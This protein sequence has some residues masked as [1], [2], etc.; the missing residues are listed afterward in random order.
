MNERS[1]RVLEFDKVKN[2]LIDFA[3][4]E[5]GKEKC[6][7]IKPIN[8]IDEI[9]FLQEQTSEANR[10][11]SKRGNPLF[12]DYTTSLTQLYLQKKVGHS[13]LSICLE[14][15]MVCEL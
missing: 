11:I 4:S 3:Q 2:T 5:I 15:Q 8:D 10:L 13:A 6:E 1:I 7:S 14:L 12:L 9:S